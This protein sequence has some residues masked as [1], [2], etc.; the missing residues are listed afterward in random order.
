LSSNAEL[1]LSKLGVSEEYKKL[2]R[3]YIDYANRFRHAPSKTKPRPG[4][5]YKEAESFIYMTGMFLRLASS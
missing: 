5:Q 4:I 3:G 1:F 2:L